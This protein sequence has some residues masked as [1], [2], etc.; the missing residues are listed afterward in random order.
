[1][2]NFEILQSASGFSNNFNLIHLSSIAKF[3]LFALLGLEQLCKPCLTFATILIFQGCH[4]YLCGYAES[5]LPKYKPLVR[6]LGA[7]LSYDQLDAQVTHILVGT[8]PID[9]Q[10]AEMVFCDFEGLQ[11]TGS[12]QLKNPAGDV[13]VVSARWLLDCATQP[14]KPRRLDTDAYLYEPVAT[15][16]A[17]DAPATDAVFKKPLNARNVENRSSAQKDRPAGG[18]LGTQKNSGL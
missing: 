5:A 7:T 1:M 17:G 4:L 6:K 3:R 15:M 8:A 2:P 10:T 11:L 16:R 9:P 14:E 13:P 12:F 18:T